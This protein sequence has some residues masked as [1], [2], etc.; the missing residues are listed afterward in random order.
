MPT[1]F[2]FA[3]VPS[4]LETAPSIC[5]LNSASISIRKFTVE[6]VPTPKTDKPLTYCKAAS[7]T[8]FLSSSCVIVFLLH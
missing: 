3:V 6:P 1:F 2:S 7:A 8:F 4:E 5:D